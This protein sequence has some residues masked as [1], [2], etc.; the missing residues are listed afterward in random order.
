M[1]EN[2]IELINTSYHKKITDQH[3]AQVNFTAIMPD[4]LVQMYFDK[5]SIDHVN[6]GRLRFMERV[7][8][9]DNANGNDVI[10]FGR[11]S[12]GYGY[13]ITQDIYGAITQTQGVKK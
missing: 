8:T 12:H 2:D 7:H 10:V 13:S 1:N 4:E 9:I 5:T 3:L 11:V 6:L